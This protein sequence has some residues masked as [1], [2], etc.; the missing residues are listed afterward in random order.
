MSVRR[1]GDAY[2]V[3]VTLPGHGRIE[4]SLPPGATLRDARALEARLLRGQLDS[5]LGR[6]QEP[7]LAALVARWLEGDAKGLRDYHGVVLRAKGMVEFLARPVSGAVQAA[8][9]MVA[10]A[11]KAGNKPATINRKL[12]LLRRVLRLAYREWQVPGVT[13]DYS[14]RIKL[15]RENNQRHHYLLPAELQ[16]LAAAAEAR[17]AGAGQMVLFAAYTGMRRSEMLRLTAADVHKGYVLLDTKTKT[18]KPRMVPLTPHAQEI[19]ANIPWKCTDQQLRT[20]FEAAREECKVPHIRLHDVRHTY[21]SWILQAGGSLVD[22][23]DLLGHASVATTNRYA[24][25]A[26]QHLTAAVGRLPRLGGSDAG[27]PD[28]DPP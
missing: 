7:T 20:A 28:A 5:L 17:R 8:E 9:D 13:Q 12:A 26:A 16:A 27:Q 19:A 2:Q 10:A 24:H 6:V 21:A 25:L 23:R 22:V 11:R 15:L 4:R 3:R 14:Q 1:R 18:G